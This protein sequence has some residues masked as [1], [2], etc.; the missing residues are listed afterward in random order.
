MTDELAD[1][2]PR[3]D[4]EQPPAPQTVFEIAEPATPDAPDVGAEPGG[5]RT[6]S[7]GGG[8]PRV[9]EALRYAGAELR[10]GV[11]EQGVNGGI[12]LT[13]YVRWFGG[14]LPPSPWCAY[15]VSWCWDNATDR[16]HKTPWVN[17]G[18]VPSIHE[19][20]SA[21]RKLVRRPTPGDLFGVRGD[22]IGWVLTS[23]G[24]AITTIEGNASGCVRSYRRSASGLWF[25]RIA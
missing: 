1:V 9:A 15:F 3:F 13:R 22:H 10:R 6:V 4:D 2:D 20:A 21:H 25:A 5:R 11:C 18:Y 7:G 16:N 19:W 14:N 17:P 23:S 8:D 24:S 12:P